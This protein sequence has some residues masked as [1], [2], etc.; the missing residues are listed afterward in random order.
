[1][2]SEIYT[3]NFFK[4]KRT[5]A[6]FYDIWHRTL[7][8]NGDYWLGNNLDQ[9]ILS[10][11][12]YKRVCDVIAVD[13]E[14]FAIRPRWTWDKYRRCRDPLK[15]INENVFGLNYDNFKKLAYGCSIIPPFP[16]FSEEDEGSIREVLKK[17]IKE[18]DSFDFATLNDVEWSQLS[19]MMRANIRPDL[20]VKD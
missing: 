1:M 16:Y 13:P 6:F 11:V 20:L 12:T 7:G 10:F 17:W 8:P 15:R 18:V 5:I 14:R 2:P 19:F 3:E 4:A 9:M